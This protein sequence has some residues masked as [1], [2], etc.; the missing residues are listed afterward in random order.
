MLSHSSPRM[1]RTPRDKLRMFRFCW[2]RLHFFC[3]ILIYV[4]LKLKFMFITLLHP[5]YVNHISPCLLVKRPFDIVVFQR[6][7][8]IRM[9]LL[10]VKFVYCKRKEHAR[11]PEQ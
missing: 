7:Q 6:H 1:A 4:N 8:Q 3:Q 9:A 2:A 5:M 10:R 11:M